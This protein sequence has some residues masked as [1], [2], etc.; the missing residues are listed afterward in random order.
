[1]SSRVLHWFVFI[2]SSGSEPLPTM[3]TEEDQGQ[4]NVANASPVPQ[5]LGTWPSGFSSIP[6]T[7]F[8]QIFSQ[9]F[10]LPLCSGSMWSW[11]AQYRLWI[12]VSMKCSPSRT[13]GTR[14]K[15]FQTAQVRIHLPL[16]FCHSNLAQTSQ[17]KPLA[18]ILICTSRL[19]CWCGRGLA[20][21]TPL[22]WSV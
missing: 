5:W 7:F 13:G 15:G 12:S 8:P 18:V 3:N 21:F 14:Y 2:N 19:R 20:L 10:P 11:A 9:I 1:M 6:W 4:P 17:P 22:A 16:K